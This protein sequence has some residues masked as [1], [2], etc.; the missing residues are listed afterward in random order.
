MSRV[1]IAALCLGLSSCAHYHLPASR[2]ET[3]EALGSGK[4]GRLE[5]VGLISGHDLIATPTVGSP[6][7]EDGT[8][9]DPELQGAISLAF[10]FVTS[11]SE[12]I[13]AGVRL[14]P[15]AP[16][17]LRFKMQLS[18]LPEKVADEGNFSTAIAITP[19][20]LI[21]SSSGTTSTYLA[22][23]LALLAGYRL[24]KQHLLSLAP[25]F[26][27]ASLSGIPLSGTTPTVS[28]TIATGSASATRYGAAL[29][30][31]YSL[32]AIL[33]RA[34]LAYTLGSFGE[35]QLS[36]LHLSALFGF[37]L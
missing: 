1:L 21:G 16:L 15:H 31:Q 30:Y 28:G 4:L 8:V 7:P 17:T 9:P 19:G 35:A 12:T 24:N 10:G 25:F 29:G 22:G 32:E 36:K 23:D 2:L 37:H 33:L 6:D 5:L 26:G 20:I 34:E 3:P 27:F 18:G 11:L 13:D 14:A